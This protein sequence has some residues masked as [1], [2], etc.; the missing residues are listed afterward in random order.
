MTDFA[1]EPIWDALQAERGGRAPAEFE[2]HEDWDQGEEARQAEE[3]G[4]AEA[5]STAA[6]FLG[7][8]PAKPREW[9]PAQFAN[10]D[11]AELAERVATG[12]DE[13]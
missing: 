3:R 10:L 1:V 12:D 9:P 5:D 2:G 8:D 7:W 11:E 6:D 13:L 4:R